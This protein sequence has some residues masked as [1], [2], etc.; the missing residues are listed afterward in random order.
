VLEEVLHDM[1]RMLHLGP[2]SGFGM[3]YLGNEITQ[4]RPA[5][6]LS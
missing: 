2:D 3:F 1:E 5:S 6:V 4:G